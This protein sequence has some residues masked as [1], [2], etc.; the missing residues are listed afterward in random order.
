MLTHESRGSDVGPPPA[1]N[2]TR[3]G[4]ARAIS[5]GRLDPEARACPTAPGFAERVRPGGVSLHL[6]ATVHGC[7]RSQVLAALAVSGG[8]GRAGA[9]GQGQDQDRVGV[10]NRLET[11]FSGDPPASS[12]GRAPSRIGS[13]TKRTEHETPR[14][15]RRSSPSRTR[16]V[17][18]DV[19]KVVPRAS[20]RARESTDRDHPGVRPGHGTVGTAAVSGQGRPK[21]RLCLARPWR[22]RSA[23]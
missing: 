2:S 6:V 3:P 18:T 12:C 19:G 17:R 20:K 7:V 11:P 10:A 23:P 22:G 5:C 13:P 4:Q 14:E 15:P 9:E 21:F 1:R 16:S 8:H